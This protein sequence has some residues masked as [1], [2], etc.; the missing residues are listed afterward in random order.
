MVITHACQ[1]FFYED[2]CMQKEAVVQA[3]VV[4]SPQ[5]TGSVQIN[6]QEDMNLQAR[7]SKLFGRTPSLGTSS[8]ECVCV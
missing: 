3:A 5:V 4:V 2:H 6:V 7:V 1:R 8:S